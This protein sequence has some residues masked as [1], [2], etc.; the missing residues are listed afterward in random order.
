MD[1][2][3][4]LA[5]I[6][7][8]LAVGPQ[9]HRGADRPVNGLGQVRTVDEGAFL[10][11]KAARWDYEPGLL[12]E[13]RRE[14]ILHDQERQSPQHRRL[15]SLQPRLGSRRI[16]GRQIERLDLTAARGFDD[17]REANDVTL[18]MAQ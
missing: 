8:N 4:P 17:C 15:F 1:Q 10:F 5:E 18:E 3:A 2:A 7:E 12:T 16:A 13:R 9:A 14:K 6:Q 11:R